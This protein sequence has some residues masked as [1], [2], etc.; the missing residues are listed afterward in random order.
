[1]ATEDQERLEVLYQDILEDGLPAP[2]LLAQYATA[3]NELSEEERLEVESAAGRFPAVADELDTLRGFDFEALD[4]DLQENASASVASTFRKLF[5]RPAFVVGLAASAGLAAWLSLGQGPSVGDVQPTPYLASTT[6][7]APNPKAAL[8]PVPTSIIPEVVELAQDQTNSDESAPGQSESTS[9]EGLALELASES[10]PPFIQE[11]VDDP[12]G[13]DG[14][15]AAEAESAPER[16]EILLA[17]LTPTYQM[18]FNSPLRQRD[19][20]GFRAA[21]Q[22]APLITLLAPAHLARTTSKN[23]RLFW[24]ID[25]VPDVGAFYLTISTV[26]GEESIVENLALAP[27]AKSGI[28]GIDLATLEVKVG[29]NE[30]YRWS[31]A[32]RL[33]PEAAPS[34]FA[35]GWIVG[36]E[37]DAQ[38]RARLASA[39]SGEKP[40]VLARDGYWYDALQATVEL[41]EQYPLDHRTQA[42]LDALLE[43]GGIQGIGD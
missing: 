21:P 7:E 16:P 11:A 43:Q 3:P 36:V 22:G 24:H 26:H 30:E 17:M 2:D 34:T 4:A 35:F 13:D 27:P 1:M 23:P 29:K 10:A 32:H 39:P 15:A 33:N 40:D 25:R 6:P 20:G 5:M 38:T 42:A 18:P 41:V 12:D 19:I 28:Q 31:I 8:E 9:I 37:P 14:L